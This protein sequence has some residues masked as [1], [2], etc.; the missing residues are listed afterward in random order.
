MTVILSPDS[1][2]KLAETHKGILLLRLLPATPHRDRVAPESR[3]HA[4]L[5]NVLGGDFH[6]RAMRLVV[7]PLDLWD[8]E[9][10]AYHVVTCR[11]KQRFEAK[12]DDILSGIEAH[13][14]I[15]GC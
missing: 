10:C 3:G 7:Q 8:T 13:G 14:E 5:V 6:N 12:V 4:G 15:L 2:L 1:A 9:T 11:E